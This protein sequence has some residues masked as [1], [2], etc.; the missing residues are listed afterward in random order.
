MEYKLPN[1]L[2]VIK[3][4]NTYDE[5]IYLTNHRANIIENNNIP[6]HIYLFI[7]QHRFKIWNDDEEVFDLICINEEFRYLASIGYDDIDEKIRLHICIKKNY[8]NCFK[9]LLNC[10]YPWDEDTIILALECNRIEYIKY[11]YEFYKTL[12]YSQHK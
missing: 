12:W 11:L 2:V 10:Y 7:F 6:L 1:S 3:D 4:L 5:Y 9:V 8:F